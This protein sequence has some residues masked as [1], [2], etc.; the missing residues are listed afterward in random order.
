MRIRVT[1]DGPGV[2]RDLRRRVFEPGFTTKE[3]GW[4]IGL[5][6]AQ[7]DRRAQWHKRFAHAR[8]DRP[9]RAVRVYF[10][11]MTSVDVREGPA[12]RD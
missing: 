7:P 3:R 1:D 8:A 4:G 10:P 12:R 5:A 9:G 6:L 11:C 2:P